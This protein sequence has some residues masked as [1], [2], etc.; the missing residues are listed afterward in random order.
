MVALIGPPPADFIRRSETTGQCFDHNVSALAIGFSP[1]HKISILEL[2][3]FLGLLMKMQ[4]C[5]RLPWKA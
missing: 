5:R 3:L 4:L 1:S 2:T